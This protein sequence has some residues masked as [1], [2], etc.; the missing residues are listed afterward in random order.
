MRS[1]YH[2]CWIAGLAALLLAVGPLSAQAQGLSLG[3]PLP[4]ASGL[5]DVQGGAA[6]LASLAGSNGTVVIFWSNACPWVEQYEERI[7]RLA[8]QYQEQG[9]RFVLINSNNASAFPGESL[10]ES[11][12]RAAGYD[13]V[14][15]L[16]DE[17][18]AAAEAFGAARTPHVFVFD[19][20][21]SLV[22]A[23]AVDDSPGDAQNVQKTYLADA[24]SA[25]TDGGDVP[26]A[27]TNAFGCIIKP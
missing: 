4:S 23:G 1:P 16:R 5:Q 2:I 17:G 14:T 8:Q 25:I 12:K 13:G 11:K 15:Y 26:V 20:G 27:Q 3:S 10:A 6:E 24:L 9:V 18:G 7:L 19:S 22:Y 21:R